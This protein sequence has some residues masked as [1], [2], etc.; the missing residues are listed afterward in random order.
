[1]SKTNGRS[2]PPV[3][4]DRV[5]ARR[6][7]ALFI[8]ETDSEQATL[9]DNG[10]A[11]VTL[12]QL[13]E[14]AAVDL[15]GVTRIVLVP[16]LDNVD[17]C[18]IPDV[19]R[20]LEG[21]GFDGTVACIA[22]PEGAN[23]VCQ[24][25]TLYPSAFR[26]TWIALLG[27]AAP[28]A[29]GVPGRP[30][31]GARRATTDKEA[32]GADQG[33]R[34]RLRS[35]AGTKAKVRRWLVNKYVP[36]GYITLV[37]GD[38]AGGKSTFVD[39]L[40][41]ALSSGL[42]AWGLDYPAPPACDTIL[43]SCEDGLED[44]TVPRL[45]AHGADFSHINVI[46]PI[47]DKDGNRSEFGFAHLDELNRILVQNPEVKCV[48]I[49]PV[50][51]FVGGTG[52]DDYSDSKLRA[53]LRPLAKIAHDR[54]VAVILIAHLGKA[55]HANAVNRILGSVGYKN[56]ARSVLMLARD[57]EEE[58]R[59]IVAQAKPQFSRRVPAITFTIAQV[60]EPR[61]TEIVKDIGSELTDEDDK[62]A[63]RD[64]IYQ[65]VWGESVNLTV[66]E[67]FATPQAEEGAGKKKKAERCAEWLE[68][69][70]TRCPRPHRE[71]KALADKEGF[72]RQCLRDA[73][74]ALRDR[75]VS[76]L[77]W[78]MY[79]AGGEWWVGFGDCSM[80]REKHAILG[81]AGQTGQTGQTGSPSANGACE[82]HCA[83]Q[84]DQS[85][86]S[87]DTP[88]DGNADPALWPPRLR[89]AVARLGWR[90][91]EDAGEAALGFGAHLATDEECGR[92]LQHLKTKGAD[93][94]ADHAP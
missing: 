53:L 34:F 50:G 31:K 80:W 19:L 46:E 37:A 88:P 68:D 71:V 89:E 93:D 7:G 49:D 78:K 30:G 15:D 6:S 74:D 83:V 87:D 40:V 75:N 42:P 72:G 11:A 58:D 76:P 47:P 63:L 85:V 51:A 9:Q 39:A 73:G 21:T 43:V 20:H 13:Q 27:A 26:E 64:Q 55:N 69:L 66:N 14:L 54:N 90:V 32:A 65:C 12:E 44:V 33:E 77:V 57:A 38:G 28:V 70:L 62:I 1:M 3:T 84:S 81:D 35:L 5:T 16:R 24:L 41:A 25:D 48:V 60:A 8:V 45:A 67:I 91:V 61:M 22:L 17:F 92:V 2:P 23:G 82:Q 52:V 36:L 59:R 56:A 79:M 29:F 86:Q 94:H 10:Y 18:P 4:W